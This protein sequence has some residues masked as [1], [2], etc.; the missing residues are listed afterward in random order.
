M[1]EE[2]QEPATKDAA[3]E[4]SF[5]TSPDPQDNPFLNIILNVLAP[6]MVLS[7]FSKEGDK[8]WHI[9]PQ[10]AIVIALALPIGYGI[11]HFAK[12]RK[13]NIFSFVGFLSVLLTG[14]IT[15][16]LWSGG[17]GVRQNAALLFGVKEAIQPLILGSLFLIT[18]RMAKPLFNA[19]FYSDALFDVTRIEQRVVEIGEQVKYKSLLWK[20]TLLFF[21]SFLLS[22]VMNLFLAYYF[23][24]DLDPMA[25]NWKELYNKDVARITGWGMLVIG[26]PLM[27]V[28]MFIL[29][30][31]IRNLRALT[32]LETEKILQA[33]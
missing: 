30:Y 13:M 10:L 7:Y 15:I 11:W 8:A 4:D 2:A 27:V 33:R 29:W 3:P 26:G 12:Y 20:S 16:Y 5:K 1:S 6:V 17:V 14:A 21:G 24:G 18:H 9:G 32:G 31:L 28:G 22:S 19:F 25:S 23:L